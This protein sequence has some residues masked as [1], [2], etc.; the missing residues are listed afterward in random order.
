MV[1][2]LE[3]WCDLLSQPKFI[4]GWPDW[5][6]IPIAQEDK[7]TALT[8]GRVPLRSQSAQR[9]EILTQLQDENAIALE[10]VRLR[11]AA[12]AERYMEDMTTTLEVLYL[13]RWVCISRIDF[14]PYAAHANKHWRRFK[15]PAEV[16]GSHIH[17]CQNNA[18]LGLE[19]FT[20]REN[21]PVAMPLDQEPRSFR[22]VL[23][24]IEKEFGVSGLADLPPPEWN[25]R[26][27]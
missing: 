10:G 27:F 3:E 8:A 4:F 6:K 9:V 18:K 14:I 17:S 13:E 11:L 26:L 22:E 12:W 2:I 24:V 5:E 15:L 7:V 19:A 20:P 25:G 23:S 16:N 21:L 1:R